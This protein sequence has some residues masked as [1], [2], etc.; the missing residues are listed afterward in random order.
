MHTRLGFLLRVWEQEYILRCCL[1]NRLS[2]QVRNI[3]FQ[4]HSY[5]QSYQTRGIY[6]VFTATLIYD[7]VALTLKHQIS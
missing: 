1:G 2:N 3:A 4:E 7:N 5:M 6:K